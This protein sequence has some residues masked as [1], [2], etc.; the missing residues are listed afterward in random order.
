MP[1]LSLDLDFQLANVFFVFNDVKRE[2]VGRF[3]DTNGMVDH[4]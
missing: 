4:H 3:V 2:V 1:V